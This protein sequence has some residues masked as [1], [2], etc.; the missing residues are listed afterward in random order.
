MKKQCPIC[1]QTKTKIYLKGVQS[2]Y[3]SKPSNIYSCDNCGHFFTDPVPSSKELDD[4]YTNRY[5]YNVHSVIHPEK[6]QR[7]SNYAKYI[8]SQGAK[9]ALEI[10]CMHGLLLTEL[11][12]N[13]VKAKGIEPDPEAV[14]IC[15]DLGLDVSVGTL[16]G[17]SK[18]KSGKKH[19]AIIMSHVLEH[20]VQPKKQVELLKNHLNKNGLLVIIVPNSKAPTRKWF[21]KYWGY[22]QAPIH[23]N[24][25]NNQSITH[26]LKDAGYEVDSIKYVGADSLFFLSSLANRVGAKNETNELSLPKRTV[27][28]G[29]SLTL[30]PWYYMG[31]ED[32]IVVAKKP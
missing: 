22:W 19:D 21:G 11:A 18:S 8:A 23:I 27:V 25:F 29:A 24:H 4:I 15:K 6:K 7:A 14:Q 5:A 2:V 26:L 16:E 12:K 17:F 13:G 30:R 9:S 32:M 1:K 28:K 31:Q 10:G 3:S 20:I